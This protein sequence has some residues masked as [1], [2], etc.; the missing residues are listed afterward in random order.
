MERVEVHVDS[1]TAAYLRDDARRRGASV[2][3]AAAHRLRD[4]AL[5]DSVRL[6]AERLPEQFWQDA[7]AESATASST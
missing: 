5:A 2:A 1:A 6:H 7:V 4:L 3:D